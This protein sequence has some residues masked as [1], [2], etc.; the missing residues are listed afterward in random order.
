MA[1]HLNNQWQ[2]VCVLSMLKICIQKINYRIQITIENSKE[3]NNSVDRKK[4]H[5]LLVDKKIL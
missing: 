4:D 2:K 3:N 1:L 5:L